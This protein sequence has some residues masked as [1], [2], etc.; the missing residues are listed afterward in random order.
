MSTEILV[1]IAGIVSTFIGSWTSWFFTRKKYN[2]EVDNT[3]IENMKQSLEF[4]TKLSDDT[5]NRL[6]E[7]LKR[8]DE[9]S[10]KNDE[11]ENEIRTLKNQVFDVM[12]N[13]CYEFSCSHRVKVPKL[14]E[15]KSE[16]K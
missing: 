11:L 9:T 12:T 14:V 2:S 3:V 8:L 7:T 10:R 16:K 5:K 1:A 4:Y 6:D 13:I 15:Q